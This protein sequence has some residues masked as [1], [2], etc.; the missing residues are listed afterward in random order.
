MT[1]SATLLSEGQGAGYKG[2]GQTRALR[3]QATVSCGV[4]VSLGDSGQ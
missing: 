4:L 3:S 1:S 2:G